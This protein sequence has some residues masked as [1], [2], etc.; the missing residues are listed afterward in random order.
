MGSIAALAFMLI[1]F[2]SCQREMNGENIRDRITESEVLRAQK[3]WGVSLTGIGVAYE[4]GGDYEEAA[5]R[6]IEKFYGFDDGKVLFKPTQAQEKPFRTTF[7]GALSYFIGGNQAYPE[8]TGFALNRWTNVRW[9]NAGIINEDGNMALA[10]GNY[11]FKD[12]NGEE[13]KT[14]YTMCFIKDA[15]GDL[16]IIA[17]K[18]ALPFQG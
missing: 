7:E 2:D 17:H 18:S 16:K 11:Y 10:M 15:E 12:Q 13:I 8:D 3:A 5:R 9:E 6:H 14:E 4:N 1:L